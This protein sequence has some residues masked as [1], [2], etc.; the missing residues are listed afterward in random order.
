MTRASTT[1]ER[2]ARIETLL[3]TKL[4]EIASRLDKIERHQTKQDTD[5]ATDRADLAA[6]KN[7]GAGL[8]IGAALAGGAGW[9]AVKAIVGSFVK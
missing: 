1:P 7:K 3:E 5:A 2:L 9:E 8:L 4:D 6:L